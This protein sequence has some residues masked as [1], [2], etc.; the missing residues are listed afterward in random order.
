MDAPHPDTPSLVDSH[1]HLNFGALQDDLSG[2]LARAEERGISNMLAIGTKLEEFPDVLAIAEA[3]EHI[4]CTVGVHPHEAE[5]EAGIAIEEL[6]K[7]ARHPKVVGIGE[8]GLDFYYDNAPRD[9][10]RENFR[11]HITAAR[12]TGLPLVVHT[13]D[14]DD[15][16]AAIL[17][18]E[19][20]KGAFSGVIHCFTASRKFAEQALELG[21]Y[22]SFSGI[23]TFKNAA[24]IQETAKQ[25]PEDRILVETDAPF[26]APVP[27]RGKT[28]EPAF[29][30]DTAAFVADLRGVSPDHIART[31]SEN[32]FRLFAKSAKT[33]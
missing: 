4:F 30:A 8:T 12:E 1:C 27:N 19:M 22:I 33:K 10:Q 11:T 25:V 6:I 16:T 17:T 31:T 13:R 26:L 21:F 28:C 20:G 5:N 3:Y 18:D 7:R 29:V 23:V 2:V 32:F 24:D 14:A 15:D 9:L